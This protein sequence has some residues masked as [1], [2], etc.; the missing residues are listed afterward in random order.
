MLGEKRNTFIILAC[1]LFIFVGESS[2]IAQKNEFISAVV[3]VKSDY[4]R[5]KPS[6]DARRETLVVEGTKLK[7]IPTPIVEGWYVGYLEEA[8]SLSGYIHGNSIRLASPQTFKRTNIPSK[9]DVTIIPKNIILDNTPTS[10][11]SVKDSNKSKTSER[12]TSGKNYCQVPLFCPDID[13]VQLALF[14]SR[15]SFEKGT[16]EKT[17]DWEKRK[18]TVLNTVKLSDTKTAG[19]TL[20]LLT[21]ASPVSSLNVPEYD[22]DKELWTFDLEFRETYNKT[23]LV[24]ISPSS[25]Q[26]FCLV[27]P[28]KLGVKEFSVSMSPAVAKI[29]NNKLKLVFVGK[30]IEPYVWLNDSSPIKDIRSGIYF[31]LEEIICLNPI[32]GQQW[33]VNPSIKASKPIANAEAKKPSINSDMRNDIEPVDEEETLTQL[34]QT[35][36]SDP[37]NAEAY[38]GLGKIYSRQKKYEEAIS[39]LKT[40][41]YWNSNLV[42]A[43]LE[44]GRIYFLKG[45]CLQAKNYSQSAL[46]I[47]S[48]NQ[49]ALILKHLI[50]DCLEKSS[51]PK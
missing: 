40:A 11:T 31:D 44:L 26:E 21:D 34:R 47:D 32:T 13:E 14:E 3:I 27:T 38:L 1:I 4:L 43:H 36:V 51:L 17:A 48:K 45:E 10:D 25:G 5:V 8:P 15:A 12:I 2:I 22:A 30:I 16:F 29:N 39:L 35:L 28:S 33:R 20:Y 9:N 19:E 6:R 23:C 24:V 7:V 42:E 46:K 50:A 18:A 49:D 41:L 37:M